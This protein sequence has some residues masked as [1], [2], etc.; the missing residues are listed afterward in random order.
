MLHLR[1]FSWLLLLSISLPATCWSVTVVDSGRPAAVIV[2]ARDA[3]PTERFAAHEL[4]RY[5]ELATG[6]KLEI[7]QQPRHGRCGIVVRRADSRQAKQLGEEGFLIRTEDDSIL[8][9]GGGDRGTLYAVYSFLEDYVGVRW[10]M[11]GERGEFA[12]EVKTIRIR[13]VNVTRKPAFRY[14]SFTSFPCPSRGE[15][16]AEIADWLVKNRINVIS[17]G[18][19]PDDLGEDEFLSCRGGAIGRWNT[20]SWLRRMPPAD[21]LPTHPEYFALDEGARRASDRWGKLCTTNPEVIRLMAGIAEG[22]MQKRPADTICALTESDGLGWCMCDRCRALDDD[23][24]WGYGSRTVPVISNRMITFANAVAA[25]VRV[26]PDVWFYV[27][28][29]HADF[30]PPKDP[31]R[32]AAR[33]MVQ[34]V[35]S[36][37]NFNCFTHPVAHDCPRNRA[38]RKCLE[39]W[40]DISVSVTLY[41]YI[42]HSQMHQLP[43]VAPRKIVE[44]IRYYRRIGLDGFVWQCS[45]GV[46][47]NRGIN[48]YVAARAMWN[49]DVDPD[50]ILREYCRGVF[51]EAAEEVRAYFEFLETARLRGPCINLGP[52]MLLVQEGQVR[53]ED[54]TLD[55]YLTPDVLKQAA[56]LLERARAAAQTDGT[57]GLVAELEVGLE[58]ARRFVQARRLYLAYLRSNTEEDKRRAADAM[59]SLQSWLLQPKEGGG[60]ISKRAVVERFSGPVLRRL[61]LDYWKLLRKARQRGGANLVPNPGG[62]VVCD[63]AL[64]PGEYS[65]DRAEMTKE[66]PVGWG[67]YVGGGSCRWGSTTE[68]P[69]GGERCVFVELTEFHRDGP[70]KGNIS[71]GLLAAPTNGYVGRHALRAEP[72]TTYEFSFWLRGDVPALNIVGLGWKTDSAQ[73]DSRQNLSCSLRVVRPGTDWK[74]YRGRI[75]TSPDTRRFSLEF[76]VG[77]NVN[78]GAR[79]GKFFVDDVTLKKVE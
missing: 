43:W 69:H 21:Y 19:W 34:A 7:V 55:E 35:H 12:P 37:P 60:A 71:V 22:L 46:S 24:T 27:L 50:E 41:D 11:P 57:R 58:Y 15:S 36:R 77:G 66:V 4:Q 59:I 8:L 30:P 63:R 28:A 52:N 53:T 1:G 10:F 16:A 40:V 18:G 62:E 54:H 76:Y 42:L 75:R 49:P 47:A 64:F 3:S 74:E 23:R 68:N 56:T 51:K 44:D 31:L 9:A 78:A 72:D 39:K 6:A 65:H 5:L 79:L 25:K 48:Y 70:A 29:Y 14:R 20:H 33:V 17:G 38:F 45:P 26:R 67:C 2:T 73:K 32:P 13:D 61:G